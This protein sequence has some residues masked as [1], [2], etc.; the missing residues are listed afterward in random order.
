[1]SEMMTPAYAQAFI[2]TCFEAG[3]SKEAAAE[4][5]QKESV[6]LEK[7]KRPAFALGYDKAAA[8]V[9]G[10]LQPILFME[11]YAGKST[12]VKLIARGIG[13][14]FRGGAQASKAPFTGAGKAV[15]K[16][17][18]G[19][20]NSFVKNK[21]LTT[22]VG[23][24]LAGAGVGVGG[25]KLMG[26]ANSGY[27]DEF[28]DLGIGGSYSGSQNEARYK[29]KL[30]NV[31][32]PEIAA[33]NKLISDNFKK[34][35]DLEKAVSSGEGGPDAYRKLRELQTTR[36]TEEKR[37][38]KSTQSLTTS[39]ERHQSALEKI[40]EQQESLESRRTSATGLGR[41]MWERF[42]GRDP[43]DYYTNEIAKLHG[44][45]QKRTRASRLAQDRLR[46]L[47]SGYRGRSP[48]KAPQ[49]PN[50]NKTLF[51]PYGE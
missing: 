36:M 38:N 2:G 12:G 20:P 31:Y 16:V 29:D 19:N 37:R 42:R 39:N 41:R 23:T 46:L 35:Q 50:Y 7:I 13:D 6:D 4:L 18:G 43:E 44:S 26:G 40:R 32:G 48:V 49:T 28:D 10:G 25:Y 1:M 51:A 47:E 45:A 27:D 15:K 22:A 14:I 33:S 9:P 30:Y 3:L 34:E 24:G 17:Y 8:Q 11:K 5:L 21:P